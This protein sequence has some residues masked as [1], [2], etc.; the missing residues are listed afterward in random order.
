MAVDQMQVE[1][2]QLQ[3]QVVKTLEDNRN[4]AKEVVKKMSARMDL[5]EEKNGKLVTAYKSIREK[6]KERETLIKDLELKLARMN[7]GDIRSADTSEHYKAMHTY[8]TKGTIATKYLRTDSNE[9]GGFLAPY[10][11][12]KEIIKKIIEISPVRQYARVI[13]I[14]R[15][16]FI[17]PIRNQIV[18][19]YWTGEAQPTTD[20]NSIYGQNEIKPKK[21]TVSVPISRE[22]LGDIAFNMETQINSDVITS[23]AQKEGSAF[24][25][26]DTPLEPI[27]LLC[28]NTG[29]QQITSSV[30]NAFSGDDLINLKANLKEGY[31]G[32]Y[33]LNR[34]TIGYVRTLKDGQGRYIWTP[35]LRDG[36]PTEIDGEEYISAIDMPSIGTGTMPVIFGDFEKGYLIIDRTEMTVIRDIFTLANQDMVNFVFSRRVG[37]QPVLPEALKILVCGS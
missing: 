5:L 24:I 37:A 35:G 2:G 13:T 28:P 10:E 22:A 23:F 32:R 14:S 7:T 3:N 27:G 6:E 9:E 36:Y 26:G 33:M 21:M 34:L 30:A 29:I 4:E 18:Q 1:L 25:N 17:L 31:R 12:A 20:S 19:A 8:L 15:E 11:F 16:S